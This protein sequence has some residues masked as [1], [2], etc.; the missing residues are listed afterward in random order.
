ME[1]NMATLHK[2]ND[3]TPQQRQSIYKYIFVGAWGKEFN[4]KA[5]HH[6]LM[7]KLRP[8]QNLSQ[9]TFIFCLRF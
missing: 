7:E 4:V 6:V 3:M 9:K 2:L 1:I 5:N 8:T